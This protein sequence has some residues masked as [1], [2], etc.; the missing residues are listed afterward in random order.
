VT[1]CMPRY[2]PGNDVTIQVNKSRK[3]RVCRGP[4]VVELCLGIGSRSGLRI[5]QSVIIDRWSSGTMNQ[6]L[7]SRSTFRIRSI[8]DQITCTNNV[9]HSKEPISITASIPSYH[10]YL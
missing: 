3:S 2:L 9:L 4:S 8:V 7:L 6:G 1:G 5:V 10:H